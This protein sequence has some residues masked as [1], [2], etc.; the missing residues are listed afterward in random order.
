[1]VTAMLPSLTDDSDDDRDAAIARAKAIRNN[2]R[3]S[4][5]FSVSSEITITP[6]RYTRT[7]S[8]ERC[9]YADPETNTRASR[10]SALAGYVGLFTGC[11]ALVA[12][13]LFLP[14]PARFGE[15]KDVTPGQAVSYSFYVVGVIS[16]FVAGFV[17]VGLRN[18]KGE[19][20]KGW[21]TL[22][23][24]R[25]GLDDALEE[26]ETDGLGRQ[27]KRVSPLHSCV[28]AHCTAALTTSQ[29]SFRICTC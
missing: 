23:G 8:N 12:L 28:Y 22:F 19:E 25:N 4:V 17:F 20:G 10:P 14:L 21:R 27:R 13:S 16:L 2:P 24:V 5:S 11:G 3:N 1:M 15:I 18:L 6:E 7:L 29:R 26:Y 9:S